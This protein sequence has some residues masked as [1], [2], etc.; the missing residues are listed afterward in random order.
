MEK[1]QDYITKSDGW[2][3]GRWYAKE[4]TVQMSARAAK[5]ENVTLVNPDSDLKE[6]AQSEADPQPTKK[7]ARKK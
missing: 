3:L 4:S 5:Y 7:A 2:I 1:T 6:E